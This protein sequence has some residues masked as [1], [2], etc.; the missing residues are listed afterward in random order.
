MNA[1]L[2]TRLVTLATLVA[3][4]MLPAS[5][6]VAQPDASVNQDA[7]SAA[8]RA[9]GDAGIPGGMIDPRGCTRPGG[10]C[11]V[12][13]QFGGRPTTEAQ[14]PCTPRQPTWD[15]WW[16]QPVSGPRVNGGSIYAYAKVKC[17][18][19]AQ[20]ISHIIDL[21]RITGPNPN[22]FELVQR[23]RKTNFAYS[24]NELTLREPCV[25]GEYFVTGQATANAFPG[26]IPVSYT[27]PKISP[28]PVSIPC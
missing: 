2:R 20:N 28:G 4:A 19:A 22:D 9:T 15:C 7:Q 12:S 10:C 23:A 3:V 21:Y 17:D 25:P 16:E 1:D 11:P 6:A 24:E 26:H 5:A 14:D 18:S 8:E 13:P 27:L